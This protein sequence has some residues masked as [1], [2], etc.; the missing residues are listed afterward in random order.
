MGKNT[1]KRIKRSKRSKRKTF[2]GGMLPF[3]GSPLNYN[4]FSTYP[5]VSIHGGNH[6]GLNPW[7][8]DLYTGNIMDEGDFSIFPNKYVG[9]KSIKGGYMYNNSKRYSPKRYSSKKSSLIHHRGGLAPLLGDAINGVNDIGNSLGNVYNGL[10]GQPSNVS[11]LPYIQPKV[12][13][14]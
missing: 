9:G 4:I 10:V 5:G 13:M 1:N 6:Y 7:K 8:N 11:S 14:A 2:K 3:V 12:Q